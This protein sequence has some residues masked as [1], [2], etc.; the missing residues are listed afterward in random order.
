[1][2]I[3]N[4]NLVWI[5]LEMTGLNTQTDTIIEIATLVT[6]SELNILAEGPV[7]AIATPALV[8]NAMDDWNTRQHGQSGL[9]DRI[10]RSDITLAHAEQETINFLSKYI[11][12]GRSPMCGNSVC[13]DRRFLARQM[14]ALERFFHYRNLD[15]S[16]VKE[17]AYRWR[18]DILASFEKKGSH[19][20]L[21]DIRDSV[22]EL[23]H[24]RTH[25]FN[26]IA[27]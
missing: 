4:K 10:R 16:S 13:Q 20:A 6:D 3:D 23:R 24:Y 17:L 18:P 2:P 26:L 25:F 7:F 14:P 8:L 19:L 22:R 11:E 9:I 1:M 5:D 12:A 21:D 27:P 15:V